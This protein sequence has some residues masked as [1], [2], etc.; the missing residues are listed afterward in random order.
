M[1]ETVNHL[2]IHAFPDAQAAAWALAEALESSV[3][4]V[5]A[6]E[7]RAWLVLPGGSTPR[8]LF[9]C[10]FARPLPWADIIVTVTD[11]RQVPSDDPASNLGQI[12]RSRRGLAAAAAALHPLEPLAADP[13]ELPGRF[14]AVVLGL[15]EDGHVASLFP[16]Q[17]WET[18]DGGGL[19]RARAPVEPRT[20]LS[21]SLS[22]LQA[23]GALFLLAGG[24]AKRALLEAPPADTPLAALNAG[25]GPGLDVYW[26]P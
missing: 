18:P 9:A 1:P 4:R 21:L 17:P 16:G 24:A 25:A 20:R 7:P 22:R 15:G 14:A 12:A 10:L 2:V 5:L 11:E 19:V 13:S 8:G 3:R 23:T 6:T 26:F